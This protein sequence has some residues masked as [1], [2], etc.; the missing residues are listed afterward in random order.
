MFDSRYYRDRFVYELEEV[1]YKAMVEMNIRRGECYIYV[2]DLQNPGDY[3]IYRRKF[4][5][6][7][8]K[9]ERIVTLK[10]FLEERGYT[11]NDFKNPIGRTKKIVNE[12]DKI[13]IV[14]KEKTYIKK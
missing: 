1:N 10:S 2:P 11:D 3:A 13:N 14:E 7:P 8:I 5:N 9:R 4:K 12:L 6:S